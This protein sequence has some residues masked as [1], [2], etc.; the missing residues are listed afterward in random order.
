TT[1]YREMAERT[2]RLANA[3]AERGMVAGDRIAIM[4]GNRPEFLEAWFASARLGA[5]EVPVNVA[6]RG[7]FLSYLLA[8]S[9][10]RFLVV[11]A[12]LVEYV[13]AIADAIPQLETVVVLGADEGA[14]PTVPGCTVV[15]I[16][17]LRADGSD[18][19]VGGVADVTDTGVIGYTS[20]TTG[21][22]K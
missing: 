7:R 12:P 10:A 16:D 5:I 14:A 9:G 15:D 8:D 21:R 13:A 2:V 4:S 20:G 17:E 19:P 18:T 6:L 22:S 3:L 11:E 1:T